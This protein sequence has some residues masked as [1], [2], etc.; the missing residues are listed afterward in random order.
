MVRFNE[1]T[2]NTIDGK[3]EENGA[4]VVIPIA[5]Y[6]RLL[7]QAE[8][9]LKQASCDGLTGYLNE[10]SFEELVK[11][12][13]AKYEKLV[14]Q[15]LSDPRTGLMNGRHF[16]AQLRHDLHVSRRDIE[17]G[18]SPDNLV[19]M[20]F[21]INGLKYVNDNY[22]HVHGD[23]LLKDLANILTNVFKREA[24]TIARIGGDEFAVVMPKTDL[25]TARVLSNK[26]QEGAQHL[27]V[28][29]GI[30]MASYKLSVDD[31][32]KNGRYVRNFDEVTTELIEKAD[33]DLYLNKQSLYAK[34]TPQ[35]FYDSHYSNIGVPKLRKLVAKELVA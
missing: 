29:V 32:I 11:R 17:K 7:K 13:N 19:L 20:Y 4:N 14:T 26:L 3:V 12:A 2:G 24:D 16:E 27:G 28:L 18:G 8:R 35:Q 5:E 15:A 22:G 6:E 9:L 10:A 23:N 25:E 33:D 30:G 1:N 34:I 31:P 21:D